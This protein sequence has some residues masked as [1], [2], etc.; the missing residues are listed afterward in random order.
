MLCGNHGKVFFSRRIWTLPTTKKKI[1]FHQPP[2]RRIPSGLVLCNLVL[3]G[4]FR[5]Q[6]VW[7]PRSYCDRR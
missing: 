1:P 7:H 6:I 2:F 5:I 4:L 3:I